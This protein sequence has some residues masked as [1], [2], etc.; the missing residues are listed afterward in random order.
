MTMVLD[1]SMTIA[2]LF[3]DERTDAA[4]EI[5]MRVVANGAFVPSLWRLEVANMLRNAVRRGRCDDD[6]AERSLT[7]L[8]QFKIRID[9]ETDLH[10]WGAT[11]ALSRER[12][13]TVYDAAY[14]ELALRKALPLASCDR[15]LVEAAARR[16]VEVLTI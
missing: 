8:G 4:H 16:S 5:M 6:F 13:L 15:E 12:G 2:W 3:D 11:R 9:D 1:A 10:A 7:R 14:L